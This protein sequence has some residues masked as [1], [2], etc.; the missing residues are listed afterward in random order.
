MELPVNQRR[1]LV[2]E[3]IFPPQRISI[4]AEADRAVEPETIVRRTVE[5]G[6]SHYPELDREGH[7]QR[8]LQHLDEKYSEHGYIKMWLDD[9]PNAAPLADL[10]ALS[11]DHARLRPLFEEIYAAQAT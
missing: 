2:R 7:W 5:Y 10:R 11:R 3:Y 8:T 1:V 9:S 6:L 4:V